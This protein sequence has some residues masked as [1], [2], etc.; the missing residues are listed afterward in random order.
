MNQPHYYADV[1]V[2]KAACGKGTACKGLPKDDY[3]WVSS[4]DEL[5]RIRNTPL[6]REFY[7]QKGKGNLAPDKYINRIVLEGLKHRTIVGL[8]GRKLNPTK[9]IVALDG[10][11]RTSEQLTIIESEKKIVLLNMF[12]IMVSDETAY[13][14]SAKRASESATPRKEDTPEGV[15]KR[16]SDFYKFTEPML[17]DAKRRGYPVHEIDGETSPQNVL[18]QI[19]RKIRREQ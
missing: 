4:G 8:D 13:A 9:Q 3:Y 1:F 7:E 16:L 19:L 10:F 6:G 14:R 17:T 2:G 12:Y 15:A 18:E 11:P 5:E